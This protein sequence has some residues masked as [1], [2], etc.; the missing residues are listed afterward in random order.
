MFKFRD[1]KQMI[2]VFLG[3]ICFIPSFLISVLASVVT[4]LL[5][6][7]IIL[8]ISQW[9]W[10]TSIDLCTRSL[11]QENKELKNKLK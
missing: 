10:L 5:V 7:F 1:K 3:A 11:E 2:G 9:L 8:A 6:G 4:N